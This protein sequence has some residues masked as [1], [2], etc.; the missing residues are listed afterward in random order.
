LDPDATPL[1]LDLDSTTKAFKSDLDPRL[2][3]HLKS[4]HLISVSPSGMTIPLT[5]LYRLSHLC[6]IRRHIDILSGGQVNQSREQEGDI[7]A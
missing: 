7:E 3:K 1:L 6:D 5:L 2:S 4:H